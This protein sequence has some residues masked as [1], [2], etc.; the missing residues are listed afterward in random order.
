M[1]EHTWIG[2]GGD[3][4]ALK[5]TWTCARCGLFVRSKWE[6]VTI[7]GTIYVWNRDPE[8]FAF[9]HF[10]HLYGQ[11]AA[12]KGGALQSWDGRGDCDEAMVAKVMS[13]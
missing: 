5:A 8:K 13:S 2:Y 4:K 7:D 10:S 11:I 3:N 12:L 6:P 9:P 1:T